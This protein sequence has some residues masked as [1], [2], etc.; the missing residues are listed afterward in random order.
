MKILFATHNTHKI[1]E[2]KDLLGGG[3]EVI[4]P[5]AIGFLDDVEETGSNL[6]ENALLKVNAYPETVADIIF[7]EDTG[8]EVDALNG[9]IQ[10]S[11][12]L[13]IPRKNS[14]F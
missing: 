7:A 6:K 1:T 4:S 11:Y 10:N 14:L 13:K 12:L 8:L 3:F 2:V 5:A 9:A